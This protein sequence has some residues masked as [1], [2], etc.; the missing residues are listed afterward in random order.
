M[1]WRFCSFCFAILFPSVTRKNFHFPFA[2][3][4]WFPKLYVFMRIFKL[5]NQK[6]L[7]LKVTHISLHMQFRRL[8]KMESEK[9]FINQRDELVNG[10]FFFA[11]RNCFLACNFLL[12]IFSDLQSQ[13][14]FHIFLWFVKRKTLFLSFLV[15]VFQ[16]IFRHLLWWKILSFF[17]FMIWYSLVTRP[18]EEREVCSIIL[19]TFKR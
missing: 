16:N 3:V 7:F 17:I 14:W 4:F 19:L 5:I 1:I 10:S 8:R 11:K 13:F 12:N 15:L 18:H 2:H 9:M 6:I